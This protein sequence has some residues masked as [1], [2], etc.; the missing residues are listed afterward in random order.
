MISVASS[1]IF[2]LRQGCPLKEAASSVVL[3]VMVMVV[4]LG[5]GLRDTKRPLIDRTAVDHVRDCHNSV[6]KLDI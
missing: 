4:T 6:K 3:V 2:Q 5:N 1:L